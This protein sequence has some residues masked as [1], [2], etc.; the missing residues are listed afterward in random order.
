MQQPPEQLAQQNSVSGTQIGKFH[1]HPVA[2]GKASHNPVGLNDA[3]GYFK[4]QSQART[5]RPYSG[6]NEEHASHA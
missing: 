5:Y 3:S 4:D 2:A 1:A 6:C